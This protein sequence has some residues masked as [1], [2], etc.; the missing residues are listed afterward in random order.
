MNEEGSMSWTPIYLAIVVAIAAILAFAIIKPMFQQ[1][2]G[3][4]QSQLPSLLFM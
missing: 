2:A 4:A 3:T 1:A